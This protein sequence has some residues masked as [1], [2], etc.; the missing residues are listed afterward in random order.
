MQAVG[1]VLIACGATKSLD[2]WGQQFQGWVGHA[3]EPFLIGQKVRALKNPQNL[4]FGRLENTLRDLFA[5][6]IELR[7]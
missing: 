7:T 4:E 5:D 3:F 1:A 6:R 2:S